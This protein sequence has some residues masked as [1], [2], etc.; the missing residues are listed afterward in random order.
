MPNRTT[1]HPQAAPP[2]SHYPPK[3]QGAEKKLL[4]NRIEPNKTDIQQLPIS[5][6]P[7]SFLFKQHSHLLLHFKNI[8]HS[9]LF[10]TYPDKTKERLEIIWSHIFL[11]YPSGYT[12]QITQKLF[13]L[14]LETNNVLPSDC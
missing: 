3:E 2:R 5:D 1:V 6:S 7:F 10:K 13:T 11:K 8:L 4:I 12:N 9:A 14:R